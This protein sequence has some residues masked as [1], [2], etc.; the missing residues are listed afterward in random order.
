MPTDPP[1][2]TGADSIVCF[3]EILVR[4]SAPGRELLMQSPRF[5]AHIGGAEA[6]VAV[7]LSRLGHCARMA[8]VVADNAL[9]EAA[10]GELRRHGVDTSAIKSVGGRMG[11]YFL[12]TGAIQRPS[13][14]LYDRAASAFANFDPAGYDWGSI[15]TGAS[16]LH[17]SGVTPAVGAN[18]SAACVAAAEA[19]R[20][21]GVKVSFDGNY[22]A[23]LWK[24]W[25]GDGPAV[26]KRILAQAEI[27]FINERDIELI[28]KTTFKAADPETRRARAFEAAFAAFPAL[29]ML[30]ATVRTQHGADHHE[31]SGGLATRSGMV[32]SRTYALAGIVDRIGAGDA[33][34][35]GVHHGL[36]AGK[37]EQYAIDFGVA[38]AALKHSIAGDFNLATVRQIEETMAGEALDV[39]R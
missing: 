30:A 14:V 24:T 8:S 25:N 6:N 39:R 16:W 11:L 38:A 37:G 2:D 26:L 32:R 31:L 1:A 17:L 28:L 34:A 27:A 35:A 4:L 36:I 10:I 15:L 22:R 20:P 9:G 19:A 3:G 21:L 33:F 23:Q 12:T 7:G 5:D 13:E 18:A 29:K